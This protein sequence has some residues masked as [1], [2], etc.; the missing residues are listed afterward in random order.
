MSPYFLSAFTLVVGAEGG[1]VCDPNDPGGAT[2]YGISQRAFP[3]VDI[4]GLTLEQAQQ[5]YL[6]SY[7]NPLN[8]DSKPWNTALL[9]FDCGVNQGINFAQ[10]L[11]DDPLDICTARAMRY[12]SNP[13][14]TRYGRGWFNRLFTMFKQAQG[15]PQL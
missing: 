8:L 7:W 5:I 6:T 13:R 14:F 9:K 15:A 3:N 12:A 4:Q 10:T 11:G 2:K 1:Y